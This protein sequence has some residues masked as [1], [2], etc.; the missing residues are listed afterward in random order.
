MVI[1][2]LKN[3]S[4]LMEKRHSC[5]DFERRDLDDRD[6]RLLEEASGKLTG[7]SFDGPVHFSVLPQTAEGVFKF[8]SYGTVRNPAAI[9]FGSTGD[10]PLALVGYGYLLEQIV[11]FAEY[12]ELA[13]C[14]L[15]FYRRRSLERAL[16][17]PANFAIPAVCVAGYRSD[18]RSAYGAIAGSVGSRRRRKKASEIFFRDTFSNAFDST[19]DKEMTNALEMVRIAP[20]SGNL[21]PWRLIVS[22]SDV[23]FYTDFSQTYGGLM[24]RSLKCVDTGIAMCHFDLALREQG[25]TGGWIVQEPD[26]DGVPASVSYAATWKRGQ[27]VD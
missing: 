17:L 21:Q 13:T 8:G 12:L 20:S 14:W 27:Y 11:L 15:G 19:Y 18:R 3:P 5:R 26:I 24:R 2:D 4:A 10:D 1:L 22:G 16:D 6:L 9:L 23:H 25:V 7:T